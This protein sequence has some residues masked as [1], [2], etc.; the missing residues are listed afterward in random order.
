MT[1]TATPSQSFVVACP[2][3]CKRVEPALAA[4]LV[5]RFAMA[6]IGRDGAKAEDCPACGQRIAIV[7]KSVCYRVV[8]AA[9]L[10]L[11]KPRASVA[12]APIIE[13]KKP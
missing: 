8:R 11:S 6:D 3:C 13:E 10:P 12:P 5:D 9:E 2:W 7:V 4:A 1:A